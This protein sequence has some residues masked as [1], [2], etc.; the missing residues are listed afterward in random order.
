M[1]LEVAS[2]A[3]IFQENEIKVFGV[4]LFDFSSNLDDVFFIASAATVLHRHLELAQGIT[5]ILNRVI[6][7]YERTHI[8][9]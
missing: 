8:I 3:A 9:N 5:L 1:Y 6:S 7:R 4:H 2:D